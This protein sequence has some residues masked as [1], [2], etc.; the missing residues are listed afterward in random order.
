MLI[1]IRE[2]KSENLRFKA[3]LSSLKASYFWL[4]SNTVSDYF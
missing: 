1:N 3:D 4:V 2:M